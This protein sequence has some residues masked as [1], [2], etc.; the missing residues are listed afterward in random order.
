MNVEIKHL[1][2][3][4]NDLVAVDDVSLTIE[5]GEFITLVG[6]SGCGKTT[7]LRC[8][9]GLEHPTSGSITFDGENVV[10]QSP[11]S[12]GIAFVFQ[13]YAL[14]PHMTARE[15]MTFALE[16]SSYSSEEIQQNVEST[17]QMLGI[18]EHL[19]KKP[20]ALSGG[21]QQR[22]AL[23]RSIVRDPTLFLMDEPL[24]NLD[25]KLRIQMRAELQQLH[26]DLETTTIY[27]T[28][29]QEEA[30]TM[31]DRIIILYDGE[32]QQIARPEVVYSQPANQFVAGFIGAPSMNFLDCTYSDG[33]IEAGA[34]SFEAPREI[35]GGSTTLGIRPEDLEITARNE[36]QATAQV[37]V[38]EQVGSYNVIYLD[39][40]GHEDEIVAQVPGS[41]YLKPDENVGVRV[42]TERI[43]LFDQH[44]D[45][46]YN[47]P[48]YSS[49]EAEQITKG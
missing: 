31:S 7:T 27:V 39:V 47:P 2:K 45:A 28:H 8:I 49:Q 20:S 32:I 29:D 21:Q 34:F 11:Q 15:N 38:F 9:A 33:M 1:T 14:Y 19:D 43:H 13:D 16:D 10:G 41:V 18:D 37:N 30:M 17:A 48:V 46:L 26:Q 25:A 22:V 42:N 12:R 6:P 5:D 4:F 24:A 36:G 44:G 23:G 35:K 40:N 3:Q